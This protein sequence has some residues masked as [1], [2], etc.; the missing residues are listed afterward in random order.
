MTLADLG[1]LGSTC[2]CWQGFTLPSGLVIPEAD[3]IDGVLV[4]LN[5]K[6]PILQ[7]WF[8]FV[9]RSWVSNNS[10]YQG[11]YFF[12]VLLTILGSPKAVLMPSQFLN[13]HTGMKILST[14]PDLFVKH[15]RT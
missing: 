7:V 11:I 4:S 12:G 1:L 5:E 8:I 6:Q 13:S 3:L 10:V 9:E 2:I 14:L 15:K